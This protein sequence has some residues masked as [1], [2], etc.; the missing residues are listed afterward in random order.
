MGSAGADGSLA[1]AEL[2]D[3]A[4]AF[5]ESVKYMNIG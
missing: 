3:E 1:G 4:E 2:A 5:A